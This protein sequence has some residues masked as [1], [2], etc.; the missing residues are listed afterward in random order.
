VPFNTKSEKKKLKKQKA[1]SFTS[2]Q[3]FYLKYI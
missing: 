3:S 1:E 2:I